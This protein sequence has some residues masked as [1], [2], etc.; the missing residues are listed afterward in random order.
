MRSYVVATLLSFFLVNNAL[1]SAGMVD[2]E[3]SDFFESP[4][5]LTWERAMDYCLNLNARMMNI[6]ELDI[7]YDS[8]LAED[9]LKE[10]YW[11]GTPGDDYHGA[12][13]FQFAFGLKTIHHIAKKHRVMCIKKRRKSRRFEIN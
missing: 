11:S 3:N 8:N 2:I 13:V 12:Y 6:D 4:R 1:Y 9:F 7:A 5:F 10:Y